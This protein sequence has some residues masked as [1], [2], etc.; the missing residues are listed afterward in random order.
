M[1]A[2]YDV[3]FSN[4]DSL[5]NNIKQLPNVAETVINRDL[6]KK[7][8]P[9]FEKSILGLIPISDRDKPHAA[10]YKSLS[11]NTR[12]NLTLT[13]KPKAQYAYLVFPDLGIGTSKKRSPLIFMEHGVDKKAEQA[14]EELNKSLIEEINKKLGG[15]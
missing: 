6:G 11:S 12:E 8:F 14:A 7:V 3:D 13:I 9:I 2:N 10:L 15:N 5:Q 1:C 4:F